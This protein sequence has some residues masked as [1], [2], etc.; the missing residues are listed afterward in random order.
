MNT[1]SL[2]TMFL[3]G[4]L[5]SKQSLHVTHK[6]LDEQPEA[7]LPFIIKIIDDLFNS[8]RAFFSGSFDKE[9][10]FGLEK[11]VRVL[12]PSQPIE[13][14]NSLLSLKFQLEKFRIDDYP[15]WKP[16]VTTDLKYFDGPWVRYALV[17]DDILIKDWPLDKPFG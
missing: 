4:E 10:F 16:H 2:C 3:T 7:K 14:S 1:I 6:Y 9:E 8:S 11:D 15:V 17:S 12:V 13:I 5:Y